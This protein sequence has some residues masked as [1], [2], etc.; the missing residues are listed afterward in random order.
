MI[1]YKVTQFPIILEWINLYNWIDKMYRF[2]L[3]HKA[4][5]YITLNFF[6]YSI[7]A[8]QWD[9]LQHK[10]RLVFAH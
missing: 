2:N 3:Y 7:L 4:R 9:E 10:N 6:A 1:G 8:C 5:W